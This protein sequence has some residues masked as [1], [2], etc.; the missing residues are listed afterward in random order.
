MVNEPRISIVG[1][2]VLQTFFDAGP[3]TELSGSEVQKLLRIQTGTL[4]PLLLRFED[5]G[6]LESRWEE[7]DPRVEGRPRR[8]YY[9][10][11]RAGAAKLRSVYRELAQGGATRWKPLQA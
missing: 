7:I 4:Y 8:R 10:L 2:R 1:L 6:W 11:K 5:A 9:H 3:D